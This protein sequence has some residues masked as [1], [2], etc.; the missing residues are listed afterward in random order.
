MNDHNRSFVLALGLAAIDG[1]TSAFVAM[2]ILALAVIGSGEQTGAA[3]DVSE[4]TVLFIQKPLVN[5]LVRVAPK[6]NVIAQRVPG[7][8]TSGRLTEID[9]YTK[10]GSVTWRDCSPVLDDNF[11]LAQLIIDRPVAG[12]WR[13]YL[14]N[15]NTQANFTE[16]QPK[17]VDVQLQLSQ[18]NQKGKLLKESWKLDGTWNAFEFDPKGTGEIRK[19]DPSKCEGA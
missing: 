4:T 5:F 11:C 14:A 10:A 19:V 15:S 9:L 13:I 7:A 6:C 18:G 8:Q 12:R 1:L 16:K 3:P 17:Q 2:L